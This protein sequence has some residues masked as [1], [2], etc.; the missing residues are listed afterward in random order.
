MY[1]TIIILAE[2]CGQSDKTHQ[3]F[4]C[5]GRD[6]KRVDSRSQYAIRMLPPEPPYLE[7]KVV[8]LQLEDL[9]IYPLISG[10]FTSD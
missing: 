1:P 4:P 3:K 6:F 10:F 8:G 9:A 5:S 2:G 7:C